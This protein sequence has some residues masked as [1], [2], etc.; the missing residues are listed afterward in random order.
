MEIKNNQIIN[1]VKA[2]EVSYEGY[3][4]IRYP[5]FTI[6]CENLWLDEEA[7]IQIFW[8]NK[9]I[10]FARVI[11]LLKTSPLRIECEFPELI[12]SGSAP[13][14]ILSYEDQLKFKQEI[15]EKL[16]NRNLPEIKIKKILGSPQQYYYRNK[17]TLQAE[18]KNNNLYFGFYKKNT[19]TLIEQNSLPLAHKEIEAVY[20]ALL[21]IFN[22]LPLKEKW[23]INQL[24][25]RHSNQT[26]QIQ[27]ILVSSSKL[28]IEVNN[29]KEIIDLENVASI[30]NE[31]QNNY[32]KQ[33][34]I[35]HGDN[36]L[37]Y[38]LDDLR[39]N[40]HYDAFYQVNDKQTINLYHEAL[41]A[42]KAQNKTVVDAFAGVG[43]IGMFFAKKAKEVYSV[44]INKAAS[45]SAEQNAKLN[46]IDNIK[47]FAEDATKFF[48][49]EDISNIDAIIFDPPRNGMTNEIINKVADAQIKEVIYISCNPRTML[50][51]IAEFKKRGYVC[52]ELQPVDMFP[53]TYHIEA[54][55]VLKLNSRIAKN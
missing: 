24:V 6:F 47:F 38:S 33:N 26:N 42:L 36:F 30:I 29:L 3:G 8:S 11:K 16:F 28:N 2:T 43:T 37:E 21:P 53:Q 51:D 44:E 55:C 41:K 19:H 31:V 7:N 10:A 14:A 34:F 35:L 40:V 12:E 22:K 4:V 17:I 32:S 39:F 49:R 1:N 50:R 23:K 13:L 5:D 54:V 15:I 18:L 48:L 45:K 46:N 25:L 27:I 9:K 20:I 52:D